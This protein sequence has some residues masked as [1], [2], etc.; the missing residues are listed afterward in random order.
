[1]RTV[2]SLLLAGIAVLATAAVAGASRPIAAATATPPC[3]PKVATSGGHTVV[4]YCGPATATL[5]IGSKTYAFKDGYC[6]TDLKA[7]FPL[8]ITLGVID[9]V[10]SPVNGG[11][12]LF[13]LNDIQTASLSLVNVNA[14][15]GGKVLDSVGTVKLKGSIPQ[16]GTFASTGFTKPSFTG[17]WN[18]HGVVVTQP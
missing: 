8:K 5:K 10:K 17:T 14:D 2:V 13:E 9:S 16:D 15:S 4:G 7:H 12:P 11:D 1:M 18:C 3:I 6:A